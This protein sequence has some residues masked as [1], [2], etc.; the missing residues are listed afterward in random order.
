MDKGDFDGNG[1]EDLVVSSIYINS[2]A[3]MAWLF[4]APGSGSQSVTTADAIWRGQSATD[5]F[6]SM[7]V[8]VPDTNGDGKDEL[9]VSAIN[10]DSSSGANQGAVWIYLAP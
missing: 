7:V 5:Y 6:G 2:S 1:L 8:A 4:Y 3:G 10:G 9:A